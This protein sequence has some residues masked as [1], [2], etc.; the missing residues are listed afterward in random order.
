MKISTSKSKKFT[1]EIVET[2]EI[3]TGAMREPGKAEKKK[4]KKM[5]EKDTDKIGNLSKMEREVRRKQKLLDLA[6]KEGDSS[7]AKTLIEEL[8]V[9]EEE[10]IAQSEDMMDMELIEKM[11]QY[12]FENFVTSDDKERIA[13][14]AEIVG[15]AEVIKAITDDIAEQSGN[16]EKS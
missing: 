5:L 8:S 6:E 16:V 2:G 15:Y 13:E 3:L 11:A 1:L 10:S 7:A 12:R 14:I 9:I 4:I